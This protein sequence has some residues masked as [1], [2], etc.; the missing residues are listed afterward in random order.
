MVYLWAGT[1]NPVSCYFLRY[2]IL[3][4]KHELLSKPTAGDRSESERTDTSSSLGRLYSGN[5]PCGHSLTCTYKRHFHGSRWIL[6]FPTLSPFNGVKSQLQPV[7][8]SHFVENPEQIVPH[9]VL[10]QFEFVG[11]VAVGHAFG[12][13]VHNAFFPF[14]E[15]ACSPQGN[16]SARQSRA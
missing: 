3:A 7:R 14:C 4:I 10:T 5:S 12:Y 16:R 13:Q 9:R 15:Q 6:V 8:S 1:R 11:D 2:A